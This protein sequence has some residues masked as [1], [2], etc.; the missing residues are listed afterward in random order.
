MEWIP[1]VR[2]SYGP[3]E[4]KELI[5]NL[6]SGNIQGDG[7]Y[8]KKLH[9]YFQKTYSAEKAL[10]TPSCTDALELAALLLDLKP[11]DEVIV[12]SYTF[13]SSANAFA[14]RGAKIIFADSRFDH[15]NMSLESVKKLIGP[16]TRAV[17]PVHYAGFAC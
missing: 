8:T 15:P 16:K 4:E 2:P 11:G 5:L 3:A 9:E 12:P 7:P 17:V 10:F 1:L 6:R 13:T 14:L